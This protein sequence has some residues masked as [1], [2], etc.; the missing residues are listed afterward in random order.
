MICCATHSHTI[1]ASLSRGWDRR[2]K[3]KNNQRSVGPFLLTT[4]WCYDTRHVYNKWWKFYLHICINL[5]SERNVLHGSLPN[6]HI[7]PTH[8]FEITTVLAGGRDLHKSP[9]FHLAAPLSQKVHWNYSRDSLWFQPAHV[10][11]RR[12]FTHDRETVSEPSCATP[13]RGLSAEIQPVP[14]SVWVSCVTG[15]WPSPILSGAFWSVG[16]RPVNRNRR[17]LK[18]P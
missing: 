17:L 13:I 11:A 16:H 12:H 14:S 8:R 15:P 5:I 2:I 7:R 10:E 4:H 18:K 9:W 1:I 3:N 6:I